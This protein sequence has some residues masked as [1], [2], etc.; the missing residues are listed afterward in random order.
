MKPKEVRIEVPWGHVAGK[1]YG[2]QNARPIVMIHGWQDNAGTFD[3]LIPLLPQHIPYLA[4]DLP[5]HGLSS[6]LP[7]GIL[8]T[9]MN[10][11]NVVNIIQRHYK[12]DQ[13]SF[14]SHSMG[15][16]ISSLFA[17]LYPERCDLLICLD[18]IMKPYQGSVD[19]RIE[20]ARKIGDDF[21]DLDKL[22][23][24]GNEP[25]S[26]SRDELIQRWA[27]QAHM[28]PDG[29]EY[30]MQR[31]AQPSEGDPEKFYFSR[32]IRLK[33]MEFGPANIPDDVHVKLLQRITAPHFY[34]KADKAPMRFEGDEL[35]QRVID[36]VTKANPKFEWTAVVGGHHCHLTDP[37][38]VSEHISNFIYKYRK[39]IDHEA[40][41]RC[42]SSEF[43]S[44]L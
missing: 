3:T 24:L 21:L 7:H 17:S 39:Q 15:A 19:R 9:V 33:I 22:N 2:T 25:P 20:K 27:K 13:M 32:D 10:F 41:D 4:I 16:Q 6:R 5:G 30:L 29:V 36:S 1:W 8:Y 34:I 18:A 26:Y 11:I 31:G 23:Q 35:F 37:E 44:K 28:T 42:N 12:W 40:N 14:C 38:L 43:K